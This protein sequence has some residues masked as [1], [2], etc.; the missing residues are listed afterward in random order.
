M[1]VK[2]GI[3]FGRAGFWLA[4]EIWLNFIGLD[5]IAD[6]SEFMIEQE[7]ALAKKGD[8]GAKVLKDMPRFCPQI[9]DLCPAH[10][11]IHGHDHATPD[12]HLYFTT[13]MKR[14]KRL[15]NPCTK[16]FMMFSS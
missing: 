14:C 6:Y 10:M 11:I 3:F 5:N 4:L 2:W 12:L 8:R 9:N 15:K 16:I 13:F 7:M 1:D